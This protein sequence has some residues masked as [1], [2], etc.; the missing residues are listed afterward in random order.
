MTDAEMF[1]S[2]DALDP[3]DGIEED[4]PD[5]WDESRVAEE[6]MK[7]WDRFYA[8]VMEGGLDACLVDGETPGLPNLVAALEAER[9]KAI[10]PSPER[11]AT[12]DMVA[13]ELDGVF[14]DLYEKMLARV[15]SEASA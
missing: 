5:G 11:L 13:E 15:S 8:W 3:Y 9:G 7:S 1:T 2:G 6:D 4:D 10:T 14:A 12:E